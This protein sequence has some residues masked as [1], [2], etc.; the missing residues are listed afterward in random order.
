MKQQAYYEKT[1]LANIMFIMG[2]VMNM[3]VLIWSGLTN[4]DY[5]KIGMVNMLLLIG[6]RVFYPKMKLGQYQHPATFQTAYSVLIPSVLTCLALLVGQFVFIFIWQQGFFMMSSINI[7]STES[8]LFGVSAAISE[9]YFL[10]W[11]LQSMLSAHV[12]PYYGILGVPIVAVLLHTMVYGK[13]GLALVITFVMFLILAIS[14]E[15]TK[16]LD[17]PIFGHSFLNIIASIGVM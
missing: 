16:K 1:V 6:G 4:I 14:Y 13:S 10:H 15:Y 7:T 11:G 9:S 2:F 8:L 3:V 17:V 5:M 12:H